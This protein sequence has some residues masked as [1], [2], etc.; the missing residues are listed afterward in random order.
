MTIRTKT[1]TRTVGNGKLSLAKRTLRDLT[2][3][4]SGPKGGFI[5]R[6]TAIV[7]PTR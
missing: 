2:V 3:K 1:S 5:M 6:D 7:R 4:H